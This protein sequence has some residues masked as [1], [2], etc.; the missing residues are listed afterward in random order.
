MGL[1]V[2]GKHFNLNSEMGIT[3]LTDSL[4]MRISN[5]LPGS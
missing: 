3:L 1:F 2:Y 5:V 4:N